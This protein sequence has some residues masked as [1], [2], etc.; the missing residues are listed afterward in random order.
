MTH[1]SHLSQIVTMINQA[2]NSHN[3]NKIQPFRPNQVSF[4]AFN[5]VSILSG[6]EYIPI[7][8]FGNRLDAKLGIFLGLSVGVDMNYSKRGHRRTKM[9]LE[10]DLNSGTACDPIV[11]YLPSILKDN[12][13]LC[14]LGMRLN[15]I[16]LTM[17]PFD[18]FSQNNSFFSISYLLCK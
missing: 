6:V 17:I 8:I 2:F 4:I 1:L 5:R 18:T 12:H 11:L 10:V 15:A 13:F 7:M 16:V 3:T 14:N 9:E